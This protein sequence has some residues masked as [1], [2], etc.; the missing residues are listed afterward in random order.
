MLEINGEKRPLKSDHTIR[1]L[2]V[3]LALDPA[4]VVVEHNGDIPDRET[5]GDIRLQ[6]G[7]RLEI[8]RF[9]GGG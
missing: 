7:D 3:E 6:P 1:S 9:M 8:V 5:W 4:K 2:V